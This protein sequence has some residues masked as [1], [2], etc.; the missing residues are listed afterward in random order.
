MPCLSPPLPVAPVFEIRAELEGHE[1]LSELAEPDE[2]DALD[3]D[4][5]D[6]LDVLTALVAAWPF[7]GPWLGVAPVASS[8]SNS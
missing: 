2:L 7:A 1:A 3:E 6:E 8:K 5:L 4:E